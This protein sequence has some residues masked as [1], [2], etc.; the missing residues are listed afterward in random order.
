MFFFSYYYSGQVGVL[1]QV[2]VTPLIVHVGTGKTMVEAQE[3]AAN[4]ALIY[5]KLFL[6]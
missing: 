2:S 6:D 1:V 3:A 4:V 5:L